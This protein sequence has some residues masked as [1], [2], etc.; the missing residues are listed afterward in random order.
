MIAVMTTVS[1]RDASRGFSALLDRV[2]HDAEEYTIMR[3]GKAIAR[4]VPATEHTIG[5]F[6]ARRAFSPAVDADFAS[7][8]R[9]AQ[10][11]LTADADHP[12]HD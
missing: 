6:L 7:D 3:G 2:E 12:W 4:I 10:T 8:A 9:S 5:G 11:L 1:A